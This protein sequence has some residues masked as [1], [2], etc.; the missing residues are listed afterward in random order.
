VRPSEVWNLPRRRLGRR[1]L[2]YERLAS[3][4]TLAAELAQAPDREGLVILARE[5][6]AGRGQ[7]GRRWLCPA[8]T[9]VLLS[10]VLFPPAPL[11]RA[12]ILIAWAAVS[13]CETICATIGRLPRIKWPNDVLLEERKVC[14][15]LI[16]Q[17][18]AVVA[19]IGLNVNQSAEDLAQADLTSAGSLALAAG[20]RLDCDVL[21]RRLI[22]Q[23]DERYDSLC[24]GGLSELEARWQHY[25][26]LVGE[27]VL[28]ECHQGCWRGRLRVVNTDAV[29]LDGL[30]G[31]ILR[32]RPEAVRHLFPA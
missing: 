2:V 11:R 32:L 16:E 27:Q 31:A 19:G 7:Q 1:V 26:G 29:E 8:G 21:A 18:Q 12:A 14:G 5:Q 10:V 15:I 22:V 4:N 13:V 9:G 23:L 3:T 28:A 25:L 6:T 30:D 17:G 20:R 24:T